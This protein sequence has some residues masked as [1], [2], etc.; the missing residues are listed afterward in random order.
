MAEKPVLICGCI[1]FIVLLVTSIILLVCSFSSL[2]PNEVGI[3]YNANT[4]SINKDE[5]FTS[6]RHFLGLG[7]SFIVYPKTLQQVR[8]AFTSTDKPIEARTKDGLRVNIELAFNFRLVTSI[9]D[10]T[11]VYLDFGEMGPT[12]TAYKRIARNWVRAVAANFT[13]FEFFFNRTEFQSRLQIVL[14]SRL[15]EAHASVDSLQLLGVHMPDRFDNARI[16]QETAV[17]GIAQ[18]AEQKLVAKIN[19]DTSVAKA[20]QEAQVIVFEAESRAAEL[21][22]NADA[23]VE[24]LRARYLAEREGY[25][26]LATTLGLNVDQLLAYI[27]LDA[28]QEGTADATVKVNVPTSISA[29]NA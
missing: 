1:T 22:L 17:Q 19:A 13:A 6:G 2:E 18:A 5:L 12:T 15:R 28:M 3:E 8:F 11:A 7:H 24:S 21:R 23:Q 27:W 16:E 10:L 26:N 14:N 20:R 4:L 25:A 29:Y 9:T